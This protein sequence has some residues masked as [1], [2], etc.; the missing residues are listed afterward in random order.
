MCLPGPGLRLARPCDRRTRLIGNS[1]RDVLVALVVDFQVAAQQRQPLGLGDL[2][3]G[4]EHSL[5]SI[6]GLVDMRLRADGKF[7][8]RPPLS[9]GRSRRARLA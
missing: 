8:Y 3:E 7:A 4:R 9:R 1:L 2:R 5:R 6:D